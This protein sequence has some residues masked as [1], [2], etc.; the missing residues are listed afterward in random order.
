MVTLDISAPLYPNLVSDEHGNAYYPR[1]CAEHFNCYT[2]AHFDSHTD[3]A[4]TN[5]NLDADPGEQPLHGARP[6][7]REHRMG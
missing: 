3:S 1:N 6:E 7:R 2:V 4:D 5:S